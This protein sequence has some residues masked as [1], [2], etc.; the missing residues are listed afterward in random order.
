MR[1][2]LKGRDFIKEKEG[3][4]A[5]PYLCSGKV[6]TIGY[7]TTV[8]PNG[9]KVTLADRPVNQIQADYYFMRD[10]E[11]FERDV[12]SLI[13]RPCTQ[14]QFDALVSFAY[15]VGSDIDLDSV[16]EGLGDSTLLRKFNAGDF[17]GASNEFVKWNK[18]KGV[19]V[20]G[21]TKRRL[22]EKVMFLGEL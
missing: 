7:G 20:D 3:F 13:M 19:V 17:V 10:L 4:R 8:Y 22:Q 1:V 21:L 9:T 18:S 14:G 16:A 6:P 12:N 15:N 2:S 11:Q 5:R